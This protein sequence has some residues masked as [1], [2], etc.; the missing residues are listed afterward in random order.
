MNATYIP[1]YPD[2]VM[3]RKVQELKKFYHGGPF[4][5]VIPTT[6]VPE[7]I[8]FIDNSIAMQNKLRRAGLGALIRPLEGQDTDELNSIRYCTDDSKIPDVFLKG[9]QDADDTELFTFTRLRGLCILMRNVKLNIKALITEEEFQS[10]ADCTS[11]R[12]PKI[13]ALWDTVYARHKKA[14][15]GVA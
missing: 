4:V 7:G 13:H 6:V 3:A 15:E 14:Q 10:V 1:M 9:P 2:D 11:D 12:D 5:E 8:T